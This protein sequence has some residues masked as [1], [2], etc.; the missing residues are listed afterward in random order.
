MEFRAV[1]NKKRPIRLSEETRAFAYRSQMGKYGDEAMQTPSIPLDH[2]EGFDSLSPLKQYDMAIREIAEKAPLRICETEKI[3]GAATLGAAISHYVPATIKGELLWLSVSH[4]T[5]GFDKVLQIGINGIEKE[6]NEHLERNDIPKDRTELYE[7]LKNT[8]DSLRLW[9]GRYLQK[10]KA[11][12]SPN[13]EILKNVPFLPPQSFH[14]AVQ[15]LWFTFAF[16]RL[17]GNWSGIGRIDQM[18]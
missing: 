18:L 12:G 9:H 5:L 13:Y 2:I 6:I 17:T 4:L 10:L 1:A 8:I 16:T 14:E 11:M 15:S 3:S 7:S